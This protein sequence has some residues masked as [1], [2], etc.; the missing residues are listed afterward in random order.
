[1]SDPPASHEPT[2]QYFTA[3]P[4]SNVQPSVADAVKARVGTR[5]AQKWRIDALLGLG[6]MGAVYAATH[7]NGNRVALKV[8]HTHLSADA[9]VRARFA[10]EGYVANAVNHPGVV[11]VLDDGEADDGAAFLVM[12]L[13]EGETTDALAKRRG[14]R[15]PVADVASLADRLLDVLVTAHAAGVVHRDIKPDNLFV[16]RTGAVKVLDFGIARLKDGLQPSGGDTRTGVTMGTPAFM[17]PEQA[18]GRIH[19]VDALSDVWAVGATM[20]ALIAGRI[21]H[22]SATPMELIIAAATAHARPLASVAA[23]TPEALAAVVDR[24]LSFHKSDRWPGARAMQL[25]LRHAFPDMDLATRDPR[26]PSISALA[27]ATPVPSVI[28]GL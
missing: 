20:F 7:R 1:M 23:D 17:P 3:N 4:M 5:I 10:R 14:G 19:E 26:P 28:P 27:A 8:L 9:D 16:T 13:L 18:L 15:L 21:V 25:A 12:D 6:G 22:Q 2:A 11:R 24:A